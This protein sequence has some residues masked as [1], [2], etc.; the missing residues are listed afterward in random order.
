MQLGLSQFFR[1]QVL[2]KSF[3]T[4]SEWGVRAWFLPQ[5]FS[6]G[7]RPMHWFFLKR[8]VFICLS[9]KYRLHA[10]NISRKTCVPPNT[11]SLLLAAVVWGQTT[12]GRREEP[13]W[14]KRTERGWDAGS[15]LRREVK[16]RKSG[17]VGGRKGTL[18]LY[19]GQVGQKEMCHATGTWNTLSNIQ[20]DITSPKGTALLPGVYPS[21][22]MNE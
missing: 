17:E 4:G 19:P 3:S 20:C 5:R 11:V 2:E 6:A 16:E 1:T 22:T 9:R 15:G 13:G 12:K 14:G 18:Q 10:N 7:L 8:P 21:F